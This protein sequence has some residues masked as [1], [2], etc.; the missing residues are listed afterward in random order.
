M[1]KINYERIRGRSVKCDDTEKMNKRRKEINGLP[2]RLDRGATV[3]L[4][5]GVPFPVPGQC[6][7]EIQPIGS[8]EN[9]DKVFA[10]SS[11]D[12][13]PGDAVVAPL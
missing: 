7:A 1:G 3:V 9:R 2:Q 6:K 12:P 4:C 5:I 13:F 10:C 11:R 8:G